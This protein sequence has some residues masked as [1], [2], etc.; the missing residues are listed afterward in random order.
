[1]VYTINYGNDGP[2]TVSD[3]AVSDAFPPEL[4]CNYSSVADAGS[5]GNSVSGS[6]NI[7]D[8]LVLPPGS[9]VTYTV[10]C[11]LDP[12]A[13]TGTLSNTATVNSAVD[14]PNPGN[15]SATDDNE[16]ISDIIYRDGFES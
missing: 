2:S 8:T 12:G 3:A 10:P 9:S 11:T 4:D 15:E 7:N 1:M 16:I 14:D 13:V 5:S 6:G